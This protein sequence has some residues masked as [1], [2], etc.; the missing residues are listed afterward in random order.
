METSV[1]CGR[2]FFYENKWGNSLQCET[3]AQQ[4]HFNIYFKQFGYQ[5]KFKSR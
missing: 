3:I 4:A 1:T 5:W 2:K